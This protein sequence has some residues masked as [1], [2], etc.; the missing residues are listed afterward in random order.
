MSQKCVGNKRV[1]N[2]GRHFVWSGRRGDPALDPASPAP[3]S[4]AGC[5]W[6]AATLTMDP[7]HIPTAVPDSDWGNHQSGTATCATK[8]WLGCPRLSRRP[9]VPAPEHMQVSIRGSHIELV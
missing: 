6:D 5:G 1:S 7:A 9:F 2:E 3:K 8:Q 4:M